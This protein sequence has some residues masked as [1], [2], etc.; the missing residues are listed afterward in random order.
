MDIFLADLQRGLWNVLGFLVDT[1][2][3]AEAWLCYGRIFMIICGLGSN[4]VHV[5]FGDM[6]SSRISP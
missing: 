2:A 6:G 4:T 3:Q 5:Y 1:A